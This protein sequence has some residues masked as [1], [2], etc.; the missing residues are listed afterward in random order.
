MLE[1][2]DQHVGHRYV[3][4]HERHDC[5]WWCDILNM[6]MEFWALVAMFVG[7]A[8]LIA[9]IFGIRRLMRAMAADKVVVRPR[10]DAEKAEHLRAM[11]KSRG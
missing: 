5:G 2:I 1:D 10:T 7:G 9:T 3:P 8:L 6:M 4:G 11:R